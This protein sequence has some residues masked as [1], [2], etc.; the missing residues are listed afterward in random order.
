[1][2]KKKTRAW[3]VKCARY[4]SDNKI[5]LFIAKTKKLA[6]A[7]CREDGYKYNKKDDLF[8]FPNHP[9]GISMYR[10]IKPTTYYEEIKE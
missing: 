10:Q 9:S 8:L 7:Q 6:Y 5:V 1:M 3:M 2:K 4:Y